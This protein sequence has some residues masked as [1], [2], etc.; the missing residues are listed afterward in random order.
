MTTNEKQNKQPTCEERKVLTP[1]Q[2]QMRRKMVV[3]PLFGLAFVGCMWLI[4]APDTKEE[5]PT[6]GFNTDLPTPEQNLSLIHI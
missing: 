5:Q 4:F 1:R 3:F 2:M 6:S